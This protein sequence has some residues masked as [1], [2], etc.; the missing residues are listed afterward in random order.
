M[1]LASDFSYY[2]ISSPEGLVFGAVVKVIEKDWLDRLNDFER[3][4]NIDL[5]HY[6]CRLVSGD[7][8]LDDTNEMLDARKALEVANTRE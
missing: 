1:N 4:G 3:R 8:V 2:S 6:E 7:A 5:S